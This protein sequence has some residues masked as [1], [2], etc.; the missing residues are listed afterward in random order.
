M[1]SHSSIEVYPYREYN[2]CMAIEDAA[3]QLKRQGLFIT[4]SRLQVLQ[5]LSE[6]QGPLSIK[7]IAQR[8]EKELAIST[9][10]RVIGDLAEAK[11][12]R[13]FLAPDQR[14]LVELVGQQNEHHHHL[15]CESCQKVFDVSL[16]PDLEA[17]IDELVARI[18]KFHQMEITGHSF[19][20]YGRCQ[21]GEQIEA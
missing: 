13:T 3:N 20:L 12:V 8:S 18:G 2:I 6:E 17:M 14:I 10:Y 1:N 15:Y 21:R 11:L 16:D 19:E 9:L 5:I 7:G 4:G